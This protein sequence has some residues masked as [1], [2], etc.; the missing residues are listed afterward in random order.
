MVAGDRL[1]LS[2][3]VT[4]LVDN[5]VRHSPDAGEVRVREASPR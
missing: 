5:A 1:Q 4:I 3:V 2:Q